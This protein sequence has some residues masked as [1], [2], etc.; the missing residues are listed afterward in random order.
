[1]KVLLS[2]KPNFVHEIA[3]GRKKFEYRKRIFK[4]EVDSV[5]IYSSK[6][7]GMIVGEFKVD[8]IIIKAPDD[9]WEETEE[10]SGITKEF[11]LTYFDGRN[12]AYAIKI[13]DL[14]MYE[15]PINPYK[16][17]NNFVAPQSYKYFDESQ[18]ALLNT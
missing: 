6:P 13:K 16:L 1:M 2:I 7:V 3:I 11:F 17:F 8:D 15:E 4:Q 12:E 18:Q 9:L 5:I 14:F 10:Y